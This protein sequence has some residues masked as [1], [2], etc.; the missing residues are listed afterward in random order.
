MRYYDALGLAPKL[1][2][3]TEEL[4]K[5]FYERSREWHPDRYSRRSPEERK[6]ALNM[7]AV[8]NDAFRTLRDPIGR[9][10]YFLEENGLKPTKTPPPELLE[11]VFELNMA[12]EELREGD[13]SARPQLV[14][15]QKRFEE[16]RGQIDQGLAKLFAQYDADGD[17]APGAALAEIR[18]ALDRR[19]YVSNL[20]RDVSKELSAEKESDVHVSN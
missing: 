15:A 5:R 3:D 11:E 9:A 19:R 17:G 14:E 10:E 2:L 6:K 8:L 13:A 12:L 18:A 4:K 16:M 1:S 20:L 7:T